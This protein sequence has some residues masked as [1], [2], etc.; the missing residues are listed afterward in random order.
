MSNHESEQRHELAA[1]QDLQRLI[2]HLGEELASFRARA[3]QAEARLRSLEQS[4]QPGELFDGA[5]LAQL[6]SENRAL[7][8]RLDTAAAR[9][10]DMLQRVHFLRQQHDTPS[11]PAA[12]RTG[13]PR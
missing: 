13:G 3:L 6:E 10:R 1:L 2:G 8:E 12:G 9:A 5:R 4:I 7:R 11:G